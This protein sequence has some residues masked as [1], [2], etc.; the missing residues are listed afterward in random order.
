[1]KIN[2]SK[3]WFHVFSIRKWTRRSAKQDIHK[4]FHITNTGIHQFEKRLILLTFRGRTLPSR[5]AGTNETIEQ[6]GMS[7]RQVPWKTQI[8]LEEFRILIHLLSLEGVSRARSM[9]PV[10]NGDIWRTLFRR[11]SSLMVVKWISR[12]CHYSLLYFLI[13]VCALCEIERDLNTY[14][15]K[16]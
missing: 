10:M 5:D 2:Q 8:L 3:T 1:M 12:I 14:T 11:M 9:K 15:D 4:I 6:M 13:R 16:F 7:R